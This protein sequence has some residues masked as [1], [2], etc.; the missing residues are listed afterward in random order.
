MWINI[1]TW[2][3]FKSF[4]ENIFILYVFLKNTYEDHPSDKWFVFLKENKRDANRCHLQ[5]VNT[6]FQRMVLP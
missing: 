4:S 5:K 1:K 3:D 6:V 2:H